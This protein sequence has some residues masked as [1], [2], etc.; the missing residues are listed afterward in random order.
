[1]PNAAPCLGS[2]Q[3]PSLVQM[4]LGKSGRVLFAACICS[5]SPRKGRWCSSTWS[6]GTASIAAENSTIVETG[7]TTWPANAQVLT[8]LNAQGQANMAEMMWAAIA[9]LLGLPPE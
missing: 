3:I 8:H 5:R 6:S 2:A 9:E 1:M 4:D 7:T